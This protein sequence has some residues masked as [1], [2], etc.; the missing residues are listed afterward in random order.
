MPGVGTPGGRV[1]AFAGPGVPWR[2]AGDQPGARL[3]L[4]AMTNKWQCPYA[5]A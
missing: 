3:A 4:L 2:Q 1:L 5:W